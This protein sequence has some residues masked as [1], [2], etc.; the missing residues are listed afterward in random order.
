MWTG[1]SLAVGAGE[2]RSLEVW[3]LA[4]LDILRVEL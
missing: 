2:E 4:D 3:R 1:L